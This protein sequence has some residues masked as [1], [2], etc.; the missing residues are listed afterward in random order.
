MNVLLV[1]L[2]QFRGD[3]LSAAGHPVVRTPNLDR[4]AAP[5]CGW[6]GTTARRPR[7]ARVGRVST[8]GRTSSTTGWSA[9]GPRST[10]GST[11]WRTGGPAGRVR[12][13][14]LRL[15]RPGHRSQHAR[16]VPTTRRLSNYQGFPPGF[17]VG[18]DLPDEQDAWCAWLEELGYDRSRRRRRRARRPSPTARPSTGSRPS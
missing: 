17:E 6:P 8:P 12:A 11:T 18:L 7:A 5:V 13:D 9:T 16:P 4:L 10:T 14:R 15:R 1:T 3:C 2:D